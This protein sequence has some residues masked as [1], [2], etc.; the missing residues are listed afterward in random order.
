[1]ISYDDEGMATGAIEGSRGK[2]KL[3]EN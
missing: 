1:M 2:K 3:K